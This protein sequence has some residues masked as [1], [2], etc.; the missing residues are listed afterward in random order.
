MLQLPHI[1]NTRSRPVS[2]A[3]SAKSF[4]TAC[5]AMT[6]ATS[7]TDQWLFTPAHLHQTPSQA[8]GW[9]YERELQDRAQC[10]YDVQSLIMRT[11]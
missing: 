1:S 4:R 2:L 7:S 11:A 8:D 9:T 10:I 3:R 6:R 5:I